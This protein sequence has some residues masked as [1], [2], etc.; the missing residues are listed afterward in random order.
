MNNGI[1]VRGIPEVT[2]NLEE[3]PK[4]LVMSCFAKALSRAIA[5]FEAELRATCPEADYETTSSEEYGTLLENLMSTVEI[6][7]GG[8]GGRAR[9]GFGKKSMVALWLEYGHRKVTHSGKDIGFVP[10]N[11]FMR[12]AFAAVAERAVEVFVEEVKAFMQQGSIAA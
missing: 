1:T 8:R 11:P 2:R 3:F 6:D 12:R 9:V 7:S 4:L 5:V 10:A